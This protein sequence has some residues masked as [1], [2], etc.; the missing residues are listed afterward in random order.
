MIKVLFVCLGN[1]CRSPMAEFILKDMINKRE[2]SQNYD[3]QSRATSNY[4]EIEKEGIYGEAKQMLKKMNI[5]FTEHQSKQIRKED[6]ETYDYILAMEKR[7]VEDIK[8]IVGSDKEHKIYRLL[9]FTEQPGDIADP[10]Y[11]GDFDTT[12]YDIVY[13]CEKFLESINR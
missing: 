12:Y 9:D 1:I 10:W 5:P 6:Y 3:I 2:E 8:K 11:T 4:N 7:N 13:G